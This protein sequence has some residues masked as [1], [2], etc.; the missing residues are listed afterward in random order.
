MVA[1]DAGTVTPGTVLTLIERLREEGLPAVFA[2]PQF[3]SPII[4]QAAEDAGISLGLVYSDVPD[5]KAATYL[6]MMRFNANSLAEHL[7]G[8]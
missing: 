3:R 2:E 6:D 5:D 4:V 7:A 1:N 8:Q